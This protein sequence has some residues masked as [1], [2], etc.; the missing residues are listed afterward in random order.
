MNFCLRPK[1][2]SMSHWGEGA[3]NHTFKMLL[4][5]LLSHKSFWNFF[6]AFLTNKSCYTQND[7]MLIDNG[8]V[9]VEESDPV[10]K[11]N[12]HYIN[13]A[14]KSSGQKPC[15][16]VFGKNSL[17]DDVVINE[18]VQRHSNHLSILKVKENFDNWQT[19]Q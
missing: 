10:E 15:N 5:K 11:F 2:T 7:I 12:D 17:Q 16:F 18:I 1:E 19:V 9:I 14:E 4:R 3:L 13:I 8:K 6:K